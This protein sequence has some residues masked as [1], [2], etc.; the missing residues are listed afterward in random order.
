MQALLHPVLSNGKLIENMIMSFN[1]VTLEDKECF[2]ESIKSQLWGTIECLVER[3]A[4]WKLTNG[5]EDVTETNVA[6]VPVVL[7]RKRQQVEED[8]TLALLERLIESTVT[9]QVNEGAITP[10]QVAQKEI[11]HYRNVTRQL[12]P[13]FQE[14][15]GGAEDK[16]AKRCHV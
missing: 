10:L 8:P 15:Y 11:T 12:W 16:L 14:T 2:C 9:D 6:P 7:Q 5:N 3:V 4:F 1:D 13:K